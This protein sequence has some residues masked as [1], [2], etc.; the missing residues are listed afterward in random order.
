MEDIADFVRG[1]TRDSLPRIE[2][3]GCI[4]PVDSKGPVRDVL[5]RNDPNLSFR[6]AVMSFL[7]RSQSSA[8]DIAVQ[9]P[10]ELLQDLFVAD[11]NF[12]VCHN[13]CAHELL[14][15]EVLRRELYETF[16]YAYTL[17]LGMDQ[18][19]PLETAIGRNTRSIGGTPKP[20]LL[21]ALESVLE[22]ETRAEAREHLHKWRQWLKRS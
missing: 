18:G 14:A 8:G 22:R 21:V 15:R 3:A 7:F 11:L 16:V 17:P 6:S 10:D 20:E 13:C 19:L 4:D 9:C 12:A 1:Y 5:R 2:C